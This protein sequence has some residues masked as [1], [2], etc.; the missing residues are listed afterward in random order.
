MKAKEIQAMK[1]KAEE[2]TQKVGDVLHDH[3]MRVV[4]IVLAKFY[5]EVCIESGMSKDVY[6]G[7]CNGLWDALMDDLAE[8]TKH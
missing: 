4:Q 8:E 3:E 1:Q 2:L 5:I 6:M 7:A